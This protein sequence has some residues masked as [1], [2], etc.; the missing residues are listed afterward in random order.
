MECMKSFSR[1]LI[2][3]FATAIFCACDGDST[4]TPGTQTWYFSEGSALTDSQITSFDAQG[5]YYNVHSARQPAGEIRGQIV[6]S[7]TVLTTDTGNPATSNNFSTL[8]SGVE[9]VPANTTTATGYSTVALDPATK[10]ISGTLVT[11]GIVG[12]GAHIHDGLAG[13]N[14]PIIVT[15]AGGPAVWTVPTGTTLSD[16]QIARLTA[17][18]YYVNVHTAALPNGAIRGQL[19]RQVR[20]ALLSGANE[21]PPVTTTASGTAVLA[22]DPV[23]NRISGFVRSSGISGTAAHIHEGPA[24]VAGPVIV[25]LTETPAGSGVWVVPAGQVLTAGQAASFN[26]G[27][28]YYNVHSAA[29]PGGEIRGQILSATVRTGSA[30]LDGSKEV[31]PVST[32]ASGT[33]IISLN[34]ITKEVNGSIQTTGIDGTAAH[35]HEEAVGVNGPIIV[36]LTRTLPGSTP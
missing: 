21:V 36:P 7:A 5:L 2:L 30:A 35:V 32:F 17:G 18:A 22:M 14:G 27:N 34:S 1:L 24:G 10:T 6:P 29:N 15:L 19:N 12:T 20:F 3:V 33:G 4:P 16:A 8:L 13:E 28:L 26:A 11:S 9:E 23:T 25:P 31:P